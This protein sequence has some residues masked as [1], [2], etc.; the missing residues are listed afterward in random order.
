MIDKR[1]ASGKIIK[2]LQAHA[3]IVAICS[4]CTKAGTADEAHVSAYEHVVADEPY[5]LRLYQSE[6][7]YHLQ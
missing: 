2:W 5:P 6:S 4:L 3:Y 7:Q 1:F